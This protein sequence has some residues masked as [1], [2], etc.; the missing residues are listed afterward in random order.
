[1][2][3]ISHLLILFLF[4][5][6]CEKDKVV[7]QVAHSASYISKAWDTLTG[8]GS[9]LKTILNTTNYVAT[10]ATTKVATSISLSI[11]QWLNSS[12]LIDKLSTAGS[13]KFA[14]FD[15]SVEEA[16]GIVSDTDQNALVTDI[17]V[18]DTSD[19]IDHAFD[20]ENAASLT[21]LTF[22]ATLRLSCGS[23]PK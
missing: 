18:T 19:V 23:S 1:M 11:S 16:K 2:N 12:T 7:A 10:D 4:V 20:T 22:T 5:F 6:L 3:K 15:A 8:L 17:K 9:K 14:I 13:K 21:L